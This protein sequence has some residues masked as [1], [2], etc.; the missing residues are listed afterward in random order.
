MPFALT[1]RRRDTLLHSKSMKVTRGDL[2]LFEQQRQRIEEVEQWPDGR[3][4]PSKLLRYCTNKSLF[5]QKF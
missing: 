3:S 1:I 2:E 4:S 5:S